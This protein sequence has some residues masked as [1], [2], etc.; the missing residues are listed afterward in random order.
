M[1]FHLF[2]LRDGR[3]WYKTGCICNESE[4]DLTMGL[5][6]W[7]LPFGMTVYHY[8]SPTEQQVMNAVI[9]GRAFTE[10]DVPT[11]LQWNGNLHMQLKNKT[12]HSNV[13]IYA[14]SGDWLV[15]P[16]PNFEDYPRCIRFHPESAWIEAD[17]EITPLSFAD[18]KA[19]VNDYHRHN[20]APQGHKFSIGLKAAGELIGAVIASTPKARWRNDGK[21]LEINRCCAKSGYYNACSK[22]YSLAVKT[23]RGMGY[24]RFITYTLAEEPGSSLK[25]AGFRLCGVTQASPHGWD[26]PSRHRNLPERYPE[27][28]KNVWIRC[29]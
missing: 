7:R 13:P 14:K 11:L 19:F 21:T 1:L 4:F 28:Q 12:E 15:V 16:S 3:E 8:E 18:A 6:G 2:N 24:T 27:G 9:Q 23:G 20:V 25:A 5:C 29:V 10:A 22:L 17:Y 26:A